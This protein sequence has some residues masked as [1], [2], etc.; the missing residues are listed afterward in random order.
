METAATR[1]TTARSIGER[2]VGA[3]WALSHG[4]FAALRH[5]AQQLAIRFPEPARCELIRLAELCLCDLDAAG[6]LWPRVKAQL[7]RATPT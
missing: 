6:A 5:M 1:S 7:H 3:D 4:D 2:C